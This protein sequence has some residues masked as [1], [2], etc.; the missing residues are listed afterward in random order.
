[1]AD[2]NEQKPNIPS[3]NNRGSGKKRSTIIYIVIAVLACVFIGSQFFQMNSASK[4]D[5]LIT[6]E[7]VQA[8]KEDRVVDITYDA[9]NYTVTGTYYPAVT[10]GST[11]TSGFNKAFDAIGAATKKQAG[12]QEASV[13]T[14][15]TQQLT[16]TTLGT[17]SQY[18]S[19]F[20]G[21]DALLELLADHPD[22]KYTIKL[23]SA[24]ADILITI[25]PILLI[26]AFLLYFLSQMNK[27]NNS[28]MGFGKMKSKKNP[29]EHPDVHFSDVAGVDEA[30]EEMREIKDF[31]AN[32]AK[33]QSM[34][35]KIPRGCLLVGPPGTGKTLIAKAVAGEAGVSFLSI[36]GS[37]F[38]ELYVGVGASRVRDLFEQ[39]KKVSPAIVFIDEI[40]AVGR[41][42]GAG[43]GGG[44]DE[45]EQTL[46]QL[47]VEM[48][49]FQSNEGVIVIAATNR[50]DILDPAL[51]RPG[52]FDRQIY[53]GAPDWRGREA[54]LRVHSKNKPLAEDVDLPKLAQA[55][56]GFTGADLANLLNEGALL[57]AREDRA[58]ISMADLEK[59]MI[60]VIA[61]PENKSRVV[62]QH[63][64]RLTAYHEAGHAVAMAHLP[65]QDPVHLITIVPRGQAGGMTVS[66]P[67]DDRSFASR[68]EMF[69]T[70]VSLLGGRVAEQ[71]KLG[72]ISTG[73]SNDIERATG[74][75]RDM[76]S[77]YG[78]S[79][80]LGPVSY[81]SGGEVF[82][83]RDYEKTKS[84]SEKVAGSIDDEVHDL[85]AGAYDR[86]TAILQQNDDRLEA[87]AAY[88]LEHDSMSG[89]QFAAVMEGR[90]IPGPE[91][92][93]SEPQKSEEN[94]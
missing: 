35:A 41:R 79:D 65:T 11:A 1:M 33:Y 60:K 48:D 75:A 25:L 12:S 71:L 55:T 90:P 40:D 74:I 49:G 82:I 20:V 57:A 39:A 8:V 76:V 56:A 6:S 3:Q 72:D 85:I 44:H 59:A 23:P 32:P 78:M 54:I 16:S 22:I 87:V 31:L 18:K 63:E 34:G 24:W 7:F 68:N 93:A 88:L 26:G 13:P 69:E 77:R 15:E 83:G 66:L 58:V 70:V 52:R 91:T 53:V 37:D 86:C 30:V 62:S 45:R 61:G 38:V 50:A 92:P 10:A 5:E 43:L 67:R 36:S 51:L 19:T 81:T 27:A 14:V 47:L 29:E 46:N 4:Y 21:Q 28:Q 17:I 64:R 80:A 2:R 73:A 42:R 94:E 84:Y 89:E 9:G